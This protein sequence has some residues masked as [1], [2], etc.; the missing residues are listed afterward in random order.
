VDVEESNR[1]SSDPVEEDDADGSSVSPDGEETEVDFEGDS[2]QTAQ[3]KIMS[4][5]VRLKDAE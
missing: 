1:A 5:L 2:L 4:E 3:D